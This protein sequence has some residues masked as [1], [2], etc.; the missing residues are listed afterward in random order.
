VE[1]P[2][3]MTPKSEEVPEPPAFVIKKF[4]V[5]EVKS[6]DVETAVDQS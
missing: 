2:V 6:A 3:E 5:F 1:R 4:E